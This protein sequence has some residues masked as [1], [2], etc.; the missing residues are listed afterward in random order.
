[1]DIQEL[2][3]S[4]QNLHGGNI[5]IYTKLANF[6]RM[7]IKSGRL[8]EGTKMLPEEDICSALSIS[9]T[10]V[11]KAMNLLVDQ[12]LLVRY[13]GKGTFVS[14]KRFN[15]SINRLYN[16]SSDMEELGSVP[17]SHTL[18]NEVIDI[19]GTSIQQYLEL[20]ENQAKVFHL[21]RIRLAN[22]NPVLLEDTYIPYF[23]CPRIE[24]HNFDTTSLY[25]VLK[26]TYNLMPASATESLQAILIPK[27]ERELLQCKQNAVGYRIKRIARLDSD[28]IYEYTASITRADICSYQFQLNSSNVSKSNSIMIINPN[29]IAE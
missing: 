27:R 5:P 17:S 19:A 1:M 6:F 9:R 8:P 2:Q 28:F 29:L 23:L 15:R 4:F 25:E 12:G 7:Q 20:P 24:N 10:T 11:R 26:D 22:N 13:R 18:K 14:Q 21:K 3:N 16:F